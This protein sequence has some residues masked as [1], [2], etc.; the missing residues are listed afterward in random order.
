MNQSVAQDA[1]QYRIA[2][3]MFACM[4]IVFKKEYILDWYHSVNDIV[5]SS[6]HQ[7]VVLEP[8]LAQK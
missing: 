4:K 5:H 8:S 2:S 7:P 6:S 1:P 3:E